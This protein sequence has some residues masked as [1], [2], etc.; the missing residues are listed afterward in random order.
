MRL[1]RKIRVRVRDASPDQD[2]IALRS[3]R[4]RGRGNTTHWSSEGKT[5]REL[6]QAELDSI[7]KEHDGEVRDG[8][9]P[10]AACSAGLNEKISL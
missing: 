3:M 2:N 6:A 1:H 8:D 4:I 10:S 9:A 5:Q 7:L